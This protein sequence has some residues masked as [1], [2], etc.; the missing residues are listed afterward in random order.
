M[1]VR[2]VETDLEERDNDH[3]V[4][5]HQDD[6]PN[7]EP[8]GHVVQC[9]GCP[10]VPLRCHPV[11]RVVGF[12]GLKSGKKQTKRNKKKGNGYICAFRQFK[13]FQQGEHHINDFNN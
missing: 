12:T 9:P 6:A 1:E 2:G 4:D 13:D 10:A 8:Q 7:P 5:Y 11:T 3:H